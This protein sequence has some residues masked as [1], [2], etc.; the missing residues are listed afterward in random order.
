MRIGSIIIFHPTKLWKAKFFILCDV[1]FPGEVAGEI[2][3]W[4]LSDILVAKSVGL[5]TKTLADESGVA[6]FLYFFHPFLTDK[7]DFTRKQLFL[8]SSWAMTQYYEAELCQSPLGTRD[9]IVQ[10][11]RTL[12]QAAV[13]SSEPWAATWNRQATQKP[14]R[15]PLSAAIWSRYHSSTRSIWSSALLISKRPQVGCHGTVLES[16]LDDTAEIRIWYHPLVSV[17]RHGHVNSSR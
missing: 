15:T 8:L 12:L 9:N 11:K 1:I 5:K 3:H 13:T 6:D 7:L 4:S 17:G 2:W 10:Y 14:I 16:I